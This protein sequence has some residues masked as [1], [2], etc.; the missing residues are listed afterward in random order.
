MIFVKVVGR[1][2]L[3]TKGIW[4]DTLYEHK[5]FHVLIHI[6][7]AVLIYVSSGFAGEDIAWFPAVIKGF[8]HIYLAVVVMKSFL[9]FI[10][11][12][13]EI[14]NTYPYSMDRPIKGYMQLMKILVYFF[15]TIFIIAE[16]VNKNPATLFAGLGAM[17]AVLMLVFRDA[18]LGFVASIQLAA[19]NMIKPGDWIMVPRFN[20]DGIV[21][22]NKLSLSDKYSI[23]VSRSKVVGIVDVSILENNNK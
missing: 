1:I 8:A 23:L 17:A 22:V 12:V 5:V 3:R 16:L 4:D 6:I 10:D 21:P 9:R 13:Q 15:G 11:A 14:Y 7:P 20:V 2:V 18:I 19:N